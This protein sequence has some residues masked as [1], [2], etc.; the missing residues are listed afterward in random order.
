MSTVLTFTVLTA[1]LAAGLWIP[2]IIVL[3]SNEF[4][5]QA[6]SFVRPSDQ[7]Q[8][9]AWVHRAHRAHLNLLEQF[10]PFAIVVVIGHL[11][12]ATSGW[13]GTLAMAF[14][15]LRCIHAVGMISGWTQMPLRPL[16]FTAGFG[17]T[18]AYGI[19]VLLN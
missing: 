7:R 12:G 5:G 3:N 2:Y 9:P 18:M 15:V 1:L 14:F 17:I 10:L 6:D 13:F 8:M 4:E 11:A 16:I 19:L